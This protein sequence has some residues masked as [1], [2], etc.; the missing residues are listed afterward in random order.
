MFE[1]VKT[2]QVETLDKTFWVAN[3]NSL[4]P[5][6]IHD[7]V[8]VM[9]LGVIPFEVPNL[10]KKNGGFL[11][12]SFEMCSRCVFGMCFRKNRKS[13]FRKNYFLIF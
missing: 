7:R 8:I 1:S 4:F 5:N 13:F 9:N 6:C 11:L 12:K 3:V 2:I 10:Y